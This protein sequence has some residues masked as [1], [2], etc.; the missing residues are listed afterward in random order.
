MREK[1]PRTRSNSVPDGRRTS[2]GFALVA[3]IWTVGLLTLLGTAAIVGA[4]YRAA[5]VST[6]AATTRIS[7]AAEGAINLT[8]ALLL[9]EP[10]SP[11]AAVPKF[12]LRCRLPGGESAVI[13]VEDEA[14]KVDLNTASRQLLARLFSQLAGNADEG[15]RIADHIV[16]F[17]QE[18][19]Q[20][21]TKPGPTTPAPTSNRLL[22]TVSAAGSANP[23]QPAA[24]KSVSTP[25][26]FQSILQLDQIAGISPAVFRA[27]LAFVTVRS[28]RPDPAPDAVS[29]PLRRLLSL[30]ATTPASAASG[31]SSSSFTIRADVAARNGARFIREALVSF[32]SGTRPFNVHEW[33]R[34]D[35]DASLESAHRSSVQLQKCFELT[36]P[37][38]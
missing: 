22:A 30:S 26:G 25:A 2:A 21:P 16:Q 12:P 18:T 20:G 10:D 32:G 35:I 31:P 33:R 6:Y 37:N 14:G 29:A 27:A 24:E 3:T 15:A 38:Q 19:K 4:R 34:G 17:R 28:K 1:S 7:L 8:I 5:E 13:T 36:G 9:Q 23:L 11:A